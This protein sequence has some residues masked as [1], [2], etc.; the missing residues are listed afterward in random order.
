[1]NAQTPAN[2]PH[3]ELLWSDEFN[4]GAI[5]ENIWELRNNFDHYYFDY[6]YN[7]ATQ[8]FVLNKTSDEGQV[9]IRRNCMLDKGNARLYLKAENYKCPSSAWNDENCSMEGYYHAMGNQIVP[10]YQFTGGEILT[11]Q[12]HYMHYGYIEAQI[13]I[14]YGSGFFPAFWL[15]GTTSGSSHQGEDYQEIDIFEM[16]PGIENDIM[17]DGVSVYNHNQNLMTSNRH[18]FINDPIKGTNVSTKYIIDDYRKYHI[19]G[20]EWTPSKFI[21]Y[22]DGAIYRIEENK[23]IYDPKKIILNFAVHRNLSLS[24]PDFPGFMDINYLRVYKPRN[25]YTTTLTM[26]NY[27]FSSY[28]NRI[29]RKIIITGYNS[30][31]EGEN[32]YLRA[33]EG[34]EINGE[35]SIPLGAE[36]YIDVNDEYY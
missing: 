27:N 1:M 5:N 3:W 17:P 4:G 25:D 11:K 10:S 31:R 23:G 16:T 19:Y 24:Y 2:D 6:E 8:Q 12:S 13:A 34:V 36:L 9:Y 30:L 33:A 18:Y 32:I 14:S 22:V 20:L 29:K 21:Y 26:N 15:Y 28:D 7:S 35:F